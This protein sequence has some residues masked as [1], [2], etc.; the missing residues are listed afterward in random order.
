M[1]A[2]SRR[3]L[4]NG[5]CAQ[6]ERD[7]IVAASGRDNPSGQLCLQ[8]SWVIVDNVVMQGMVVSRSRTCIFHDELSDEEIIAGDA[9]RVARDRCQ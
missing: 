7:T 5:V 6:L 4:C 9:C 2:I 1:T 3:S 8:K